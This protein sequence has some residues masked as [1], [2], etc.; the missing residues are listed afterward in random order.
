MS[1]R[2]CF[3]GAV[4]TY[5]PNPWVSENPYIGMHPDA[6]APPPRGEEMLPDP[7]WEGGDAAIAAYRGAWRSALGKIKPATPENGFVADY[8]DT[9]FDEGTFMWDSAFITMFWRYGSRAWN[10]LGTLDNFY[11]K[12]HPDGFICRKISGLD[13]TDHFPRHDPNSTGP[14]VL[15][16]AEW[17]A[18]RNSGDRVRLARVFPALAAYTRWMRR[19]RTW[20]DGSYWATGWA[21]GMDD[22][23]RR[24]DAFLGQPPP[25]GEGFHR[26]FDHGHMTWVDACFQALLANRLVHRMACVLGV[27]HL[28]AEFSAEAER[29]AAWCDSH[30]WDEQTAFFHDRMRDGGLAN[31]LKSVGAYW[32]LLAD[33]VRPERLGRFVAHLA[34]PRAFARPHR[35]PSLSADSAGYEELGGYWCGAVWAPTNYMVLRGLDAIG[36][37][38]LAF[39][40]ALNHVE[41]VAAG[42][43]ETGTFH[44]N[45]APERI[46]LGCHRPDFVGWTGLAPITVL[47]EYVFG[48]RPQSETGGLLWDVRLTGAHGVRKFPVGTSGVA[49]FH[50][51]ARRSPDQEPDIRVESDV[52]I[53]LEV[54]WASGR[55]V[56]RAG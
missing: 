47:F 56:V 34:D 18:F 41:N 53:E 16:W 25:S 11:A 10:A 13:G 45:Y 20:P 23:P 24:A 42:F 51:K 6:D 22:Q 5:V 39:D 52:P 26:N 1:V 15:P 14:N 7:Y 37:T 35:V 28:A 12:Q 49:D 46:G 31:H 33:G 43:A 32:A 27:E 54:R 38:A 17:E 8:A 48:L 30:L 21:S 40:I 3:P 36:E 55:K 9:A 44:E 50:C 4:K 29:L 2:T 19:N